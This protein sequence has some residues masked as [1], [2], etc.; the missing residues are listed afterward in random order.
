MLL[1]ALVALM[2]GCLMTLGARARPGGALASFGPGS[3]TGDSMNRRQK[4][5]ALVRNSVSLAV[6]GVKVLSG[7]GPQRRRRS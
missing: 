1:A 6:E 2:L 7:Q 4:S 5:Q 3:L